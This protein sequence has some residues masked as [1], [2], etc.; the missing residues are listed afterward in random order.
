[1]VT[2]RLFQRQKYFYF[3]IADT[4]IL[5][6]L[7]YDYH[8]EL[9]LSLLSGSDAGHTQTIVL[10]NLHVEQMVVQNPKIL[11]YNNSQNI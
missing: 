5:L 10:M 9:L 4:F 6:R 1:M 8:T 2:K 11:D 7:T 3:K